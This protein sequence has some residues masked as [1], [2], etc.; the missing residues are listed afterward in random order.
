MAGEA[1]AKAEKILEEFSASDL[2]IIRTRKIQ[3]EVSPMAQI[4]DYTITLFMQLGGSAPK[5]FTSLTL[6]NQTPNSF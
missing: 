3:L 4:L 1:E 5:A 2:E 6:L